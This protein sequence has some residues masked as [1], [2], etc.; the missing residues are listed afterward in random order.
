MHSIHSVLVLDKGFVTEFDSPQNL[1][2]RQGLFY[3]MARDAGVEPMSYES[4]KKQRK[5]SVISERKISQGIK[6][7]KSRQQ[8]QTALDGPEVSNPES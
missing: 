7:K 3:S 1:Y 4:E 5:I 6:R 2:D 8:D